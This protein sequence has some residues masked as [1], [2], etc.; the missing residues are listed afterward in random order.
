MKE[1]TTLSFGKK[2]VGASPWRA[3][4]IGLVTDHVKPA[5]A[6]LRNAKGGAAA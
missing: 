5:A 1:T 6:E 3:D 4:G 2:S